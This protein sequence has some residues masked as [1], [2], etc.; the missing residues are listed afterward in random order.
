MKK[1]KQT[2]PSHFAD[3]VIDPPIEVYCLHCGT[4]FMSNEGKWEKRWR[5]GPLFWCVNQECDGAGVGID[6]IP[7]KKKI[8]YS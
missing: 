8:A 6:L 2:E 1:N 7:T 3:G 4:T 5:S